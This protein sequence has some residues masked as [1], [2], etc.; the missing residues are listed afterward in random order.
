M[1]I[2]QQMLAQQIQKKIAPLYMIIGQDN[3][4]LEDSLATIKSTI[5]KNYNCDEKII[6]IQSAEDWNGVKEEANSYSLFSEI[7]FLNIFYDKKSIDATG[8]KILTEYLNSINSRCFIAIRAPN[9]PA[10]QLQ[11]LSSHEHVVLILAYPLN[12][13]A[14]KSWIAMQLKKNSMNYD[15]QVP[16]LIHQYTQG[17]MLA[18]SQ[19]IEKIA[20]SSIPNCKIETQ[21]VL[22]HLSDQCDHDLFELVDACLLGQGDKAIQILRHAANNKTEATLVL[23]LLSQEIRLI[24]QLTYLI[25]Q[26]IDIQSACSQLKIWPQRINLYKACCNRL[27]KTMLQ[28]LHRYCYLIDE[29]I[30]STNQSTQVWSSLENT[31]LSLCLG[32]LIGDTCIA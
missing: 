18:C 4:L 22:E 6:S 17:N 5:K 14:V 19:V 9:V 15:P 32:K 29:R 27:N 20:L 8:K 11:W 7:V 28:Q 21:H 31:T 3:Y 2:R 24:M 10:K 16:D 25:E 1:Q 30:K 23:W 12:S 26:K 13:E